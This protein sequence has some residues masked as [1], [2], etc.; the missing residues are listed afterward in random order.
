MKI[1]RLP[2]TKSTN[3]FAVNLLSQ[4]R[5]D[6]GYVVI[7]DH[8]TQGKGLEDNAWESEA[9]KNLT[10]SIILYPDFA[11][12]Q[13]FILN[14][15]I[16]LGIYEFLQME[17]HDVKVSVKWPND[18]YLGNKKVC[19][20]LIQNSLIGNRFDYTIVG[21]GLNV[22]QTHFLS[23]APNPV[24]MKMIN[25]KEYNLEELL[26]KLLDRILLRYYQVKTA[27]KKIE[28][29][30]Q[31]ALFRV[32]EWCEYEVKKSRVYGRI[33]GTN[34]YGQLLLETESG[35]VLICDLKEI[36]FLF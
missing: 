5:P 17:I 7:T 24:S 11:A 10:F 22:N 27:P 1:M 33:T 26:N 21:I 29:D 16:S 14:K 15:A 4:K 12:E 25:E 6:E 9:G 23:D 18:I 2:Q 34:E 19:G 28:K 13:Q 3:S 32:M 8:Q 30:Y 35:P 31:K 20:I 36:K